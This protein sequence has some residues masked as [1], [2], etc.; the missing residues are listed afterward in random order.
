M[1]GRAVTA[2][3]GN[4]ESKARD[5]GIKDCSESYRQG[6]RWQAYFNALHHCDG[7]VA[8]TTSLGHKVC[9][10]TTTPVPCLSPT[11]AL[12]GERCVRRMKTWG[13]DV[14]GSGLTFWLGLRGTKHDPVIRTHGPTTRTRFT[15]GLTK[16]HNM[17]AMSATASATDKE[18]AGVC[19]HSTQRL[20]WGSWGGESIYMHKI[21]EWGVHAAPP[22][23]P[24]TGG[25]RCRDCAGDGESFLEYWG[26]EARPCMGNSHHTREG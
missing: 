6:K 26:W 1:G 25:H 17:W 21:Y 9:L 22:P 8:N 18:R 16:T 19:A 4:A 13:R 2:G 3:D 24:H 7:Q 15:F 23:F 14:W 11:H 5:M 12:R 20:G 10:H